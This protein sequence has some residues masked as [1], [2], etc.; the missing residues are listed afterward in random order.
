MSGWVA[1]WARFSGVGSVAIQP[2][3]SVPFHCQIG[4]MMRMR[5]RPFASTV[6]TDAHTIE[7]AMSTKA[8]AI[9]SSDVTGQP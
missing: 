6:A 2:T 8:G 5:G 7:W 9:C 1:R 4:C 3:S